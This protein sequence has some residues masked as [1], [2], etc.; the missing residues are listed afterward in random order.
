MF[1]LKM[2]QN[3]HFTL[4][5]AVSFE[6][7][8]FACEGTPRVYRPAVRTVV[9]EAEKAFELQATVLSA[10]PP[11][12]VTL[13]IQGVSGKKAGRWAMTVVNDARTGA[14]HSQVY[15]VSAPMPK[16]D[17]SYVITADFAGGK[18]LSSPSTGRQSVVVVL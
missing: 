1:R 11:T 9:S 13:T 6:R 14:A 4:M 12:S 15:S 16:D 17:F 8:C 18:S 10:T 2:L 3:V 5:T 7:D